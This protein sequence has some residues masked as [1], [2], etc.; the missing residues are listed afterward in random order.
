[1]QR[2]VGAELCDAPAA[3]VCRGCAIT[4]SLWEEPA[5]GAEGRWE[6]VIVR[7]AMRCSQGCRWWL[8]HHAGT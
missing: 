6:C 2:G 7:V 4:N 1:M 5:A 3:A 8:V